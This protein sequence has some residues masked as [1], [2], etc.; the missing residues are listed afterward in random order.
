MKATR[1]IA[2]FALCVTLAASA[3]A[4]G[5]SFTSAGSDISKIGGRV[6]FAQEYNLRAA[7]VRV[8]GGNTATGSQSITLSTGSVKLQD[9]RTVVP[10]AVNVPITIADG[11]Q[12][13]VTITAVSNC[14]PTGQIQDPFNTQ[15]TLCTVTA[16]FSNTHGAGALVLS[17]DGGFL[18]AMNDA[19]NNG[20]G[21]V[22]WSYDCGV[23]TLS[24]GGATT[25][26][27]T[28][29]CAL[30]PKAWQ[31]GGASVRV[32]TTITTSASYSVGITSS[33]AA[34]ITSCTSLTAGTNCA[35]FQTGPAA[36]AV[37]TSIGTTLITANAAAGAG[38]VHLTIWGW[39]AAQATY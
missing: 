34:F 2:L 3:M 28:G 31:N 23:V 32:T 36:V 25:T 35:L 16:S 11:N 26:I 30:V 10:F 15:A 13:T 21:Q 6:F 33:T 22:F 12:E 7:N 27:S 18:E 20:G 14:V 37:S 38:A 17:G 29:P 24:T 19:G 5:P 39:T 9:G 1:I 4:Q 8:V